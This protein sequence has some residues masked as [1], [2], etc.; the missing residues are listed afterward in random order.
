MKLCRFFTARLAIASLALTGATTAH[1]E[2]FD[3]LLVEAITKHPSVDGRRAGEQAARYER[4]GAE[5]QRFPT[6]SFEAAAR[7]SPVPG[8]GRNTALFA[9]EQPLW[10]GGRISGN[11]RAA[12][13]RE[14]A[15]AAA[16]TEAKQ[17]IGLR[18]ISAFTESLRF[19]Q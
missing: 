19:E 4:E 18:V 8:T 17:A 6:P 1:A 13:F 7:T 14:A 15:A 10:A 2:D 9:L 11:I 5:W 16:V 3:Q 12:G